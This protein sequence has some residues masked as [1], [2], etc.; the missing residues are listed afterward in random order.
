MA[1]NIVKYMSIVKYIVKNIGIIAILGLAVALI[2]TIIIG[3]ILDILGLSGI[4]ESFALIG[5]S[6]AVVA[7][8]TGGICGFVGVRYMAK[9]TDVFR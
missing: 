4:R 2:V 9:N 1:K 8:I 7:G 3:P 5:G 6:S